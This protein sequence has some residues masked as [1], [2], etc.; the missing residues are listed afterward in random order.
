MSA[1]IVSSIITGIVAITVCCIS[2]IFQSADNKE[3]QKKVMELLE[4]RM[5]ELAKK[6]EHH[7]GML[8]RFGSIE[9]S[10]STLWK[11]VDEIKNELEKLK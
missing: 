6:V 10:L 7:N 1:T 5:D 2:N 3:Q 4:Y 11:R 9:Q 8:E